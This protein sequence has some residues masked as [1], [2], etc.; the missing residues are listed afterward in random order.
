MRGGKQKTRKSKQTPRSVMGRLLPP[1]DVTNDQQLK[2]LDK[3]IKMGPMTLVLVYADWCGH[4]QRFKPMMEQLEGCK[5]RS[6]QTAR[7]RDDM[8]PKSS[9]ANTKLEGYPSVLLVK[10]SGEVT[11]FKKSNG[12]VTNVVPNHT[13]MQQMTAIVKNAGTANGT[14]LLESAENPAEVAA[15]SV[16]AENG[17]LTGNTVELAGNLTTAGIPKN[18]VADRLSPENVNRLNSALVR[19]SNSLLREAT[20]PVVKQTQT[21]GSLFSSLMMAS[22]GLAPAAAL[23]LGAEA[24][25]GRKQRNSRGRKTRRT[26]GRK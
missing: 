7:I 4:C 1:I 3:R 25:R 8:F 13:D 19:S 14:A 10:E 12:E 18:I 16:F 11:S 26:R 23:F 15:N 9:L 22:K 5:D 20:A 6:I 21:G 2:E 24:M 17:G